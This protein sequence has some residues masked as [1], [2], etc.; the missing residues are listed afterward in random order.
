MFLEKKKDKERY[1]ENKYH[2]LF[3]CHE[4]YTYRTHTDYKNGII[5]VID[6]TWVRACIYV[7]QFSYAGNIPIISD[8]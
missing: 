6:T 3:C 8:G 5:L 4:T 2:F 1:N 7:Q